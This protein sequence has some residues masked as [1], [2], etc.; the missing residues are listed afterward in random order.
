MAN[1]YDLFFDTL[2][3][4][5][6]KVPFCPFLLHLAAFV[7]DIDFMKEYAQNAEKNAEAQI[8][9]TDFLGIDCLMVGSDGFREANAWG[10][11]M[12]WGGNTP[13]GE[14]FLDVDTFDSI[15]TPD[16]LESP[17]L[18]TAIKTVKLM[19]EKVGNTKPVLG[20]IEAPFAELSAIFGM[21][22]VMKLARRKQSE[23]LVH[24]LLDRIIPFQKE[25]AKLQIEAGADV[26]G[27]GDSAI[28][29]IGPRRYKSYTWEATQKLFR[30]I[31]REVPLLYHVCGDNSGVDR[32][33]NDMLQLIA[34]T[35]CDILDIDFQIDM[36]TAKEK[37]G[38]KTVLRG[39]VNTQILGSDQYSIDE[40]RDEVVKI[41]N[42]GK[43][44]GKF[45]FAAGCEWPWSPL[46]LALR[47]MGL[48]KGINETLGKY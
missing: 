44:G 18:V 16:V 21:I 15:E 20:W 7:T 12:N 17:R 14:N 46:S 30:D 42:A 19:K 40:V 25:F 32:D 43:P 3:G 41:I 11:Q 38:K 24:K 23:D 31:K 45:M 1:S 36:K 27:A 9:A 33:G 29:Q 37:I 22:N 8:R 5:A 35:D 13:D 10:V 39:N 6:E 2:N 26:I 4:T 34:D 48:A 47:N 28:S